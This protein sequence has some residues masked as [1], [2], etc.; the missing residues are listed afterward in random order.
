ML[1]NMLKNKCCNGGNKHNFKPRFTE[2]PSGLKKI[3]EIQY[4]SIDE[5]RSLF[6]LRE[7]VCDVCKWCGKI[8]NRQI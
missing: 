1:K 5:L 7:Y 4:T 8:I 3:A 2:R 6:I